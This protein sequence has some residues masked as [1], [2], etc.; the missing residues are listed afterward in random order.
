MFA[1][2]Y[3]KSELSGLL[4]HV[5]KLKWKEFEAEFE[6]KLAEARDNLDLDHE[7]GHADLIGNT[8]SGLGANPYTQLASI[9]PRSAILESWRA[10]ELAAYKAAKA[11]SSDA[12]NPKMTSA[13]IAKSLREKN[14]LDGNEDMVFSLLRDLRNKA[15]HS[16]DF[17]LSSEEALEFTLLARRLQASLEDSLGK[18]TK[19]S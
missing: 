13:E 18:I 4:P 10:V 19:K 5:R 6:Q 17:T 8:T 3:L 15:A 14:L 9:S 12:H 16:K 11:T 1:I 7:G 2:L